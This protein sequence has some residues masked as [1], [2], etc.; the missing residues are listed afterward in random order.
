M[1]ITSMDGVIAGMLAPEDFLKMRSAVMEAAGVFTSLAYETGRPGA[2]AAPAPGMAGAA[3]TTYAGQI[4]FTN[5]Q[6]GYTYIARLSATANTVGRL[7]LLDRLW[8][9]SGIAVTTMTAQTIN[10]AAWPAR[11]RLE[12]INGNNIFVAIEVRTA[13]T[14]ASAITNTT[15]SYT[16]T[17]D[18]TGKVATIQ[19]F[20]ATAV[21]GTFVP[22]QLAAGD[23][24]IKSI[25]TITLG[26]SYGGGAIHLVAYRIIA[27]LDLAIPYAGNS[28][29]VI[30]GGL[31]RLFD[32]SVPFLIWLPSGTAATT[33]M[34][35]LIYTQG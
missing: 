18:T 12:T 27:D 30:G 34:G 17:G 4:P 5:P 19:S 23:T 6:S 13:T 33:I 11:D 35:K 29:G 26:T 20:P 14:N 8:H 9:N 25:Q 32:N 21:A 3:L 7:L 16:N 22:F 2:M 24:G 1:A 15:M 28:F 31:V 10:S